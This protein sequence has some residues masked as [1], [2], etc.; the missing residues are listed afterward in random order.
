MMSI[1]EWFEKN[2]KNS[3]RELLLG[4]YQSFLNETGSKCLPDSFR[5]R[6][7]EFYYN[8]NRI[9]DMKEDNSLS[10]Q[11]EQTDS[12][13]NAL[14]SSTFIKTPEQLIDYL[15]IDTTK[16]E[17][18]KF[19]RNVWGSDD[20][21]NFQVKGEFRKRI[22]L[23]KEDVIPIIKEIVEE[24]K[25]VK[26]N[27]NNNKE[28]I[29]DNMLEIAIEDQHFGQLSLKQETGEDYNI[30]IASKS[31]LS[32]VD[33]ML[34]NSKSYNINKIVFVVGSDFFNADTPNDTTYAG[35][36][37]VE[38]SR[39][40]DTF[41]KGLETIVTAIEKCYSVCKNVDVKVIQGN[42]DY[43][44]AFYLG[45]A[46]KQRY[47]NLKTINVDISDEPRKYTYWGS[48]IICFTHGDKETF[49][50]LSLVVA[51]ESKENFSTAKQIEVH[52]GHLHSEKESIVFA[53]EDAIMKVRILPSLVAIDD[54]HKEKGYS[55]LRESQGFVWNKEKGN[56]A[57]LKYHV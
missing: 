53:N 49:K 31:Y 17:L 6:V 26:I 56:I 24:F 51:K 34:D 46:L 2:S 33:Y 18:S 54:W 47:L 40:K 21:P 36:F 9:K 22:S 12:I 48:N 44:K 16:W 27:Q 52:C 42:H 50:R 19:T 13:Y 32:A 1:A 4:K 38:T 55:H 29:S 8:K 23:A 7:S 14:I 41:K 10:V 37:Q 30:D 35:T 57:I 20:N 43:T 3:T 15:K 45:V 39:W 25:P 28:K 11:E 5:R